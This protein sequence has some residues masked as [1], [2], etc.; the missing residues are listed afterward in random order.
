MTNNGTSILVERRHYEEALKFYY[1][2]YPLIRTNY[3]EQISNLIR[4]LKWK[5]N[6]LRSEELW[7]DLVLEKTAYYFALHEISPRVKIESYI[8]TGI[9]RSIIRYILYNRKLEKKFDQIS[10]VGYDTVCPASGGQDT[11]NSGKK[12][13]PGEVVDMLSE[14]VLFIFG[15]VYKRIFELAYHQ[16]LCDREIYQYIKLPEHKLKS[17]RRR[18]YEY[19]IE[20]RFDVLTELG[21]TLDDIKM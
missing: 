6:D 12:Y 15:P 3:G 19:F 7:S 8:L 11:Q 9:R 10:N 13:Y 17:I 1:L 4:R 21:L 20:Y 18:I 16:G 14:K 2:E 5:D